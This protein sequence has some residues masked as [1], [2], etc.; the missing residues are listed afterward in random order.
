MGC[1]LWIQHVHQQPHLRWL[2]LLISWGGGEV[3]V[4]VGCVNIFVSLAEQDREFKSRRFDF[5][6]SNP[7]DMIFWGISWKDI[8]KCAIIDL[9]QF[10]ISVETCIS[11]CCFANVLLLIAENYFQNPVEWFTEFRVTT[12]VWILV[13]VGR[14]FL[15]WAYKVGCIL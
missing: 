9:H 1:L 7:E 11:L 3:L 4:L 5:L 6:G 15:L 10:D 2:N 12:S 8:D 14:L 13:K